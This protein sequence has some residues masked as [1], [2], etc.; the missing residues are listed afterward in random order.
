MRISVFGL[1]YVGCVTAACLARAGH[2]VV[3]M[4]TNSEKVAMINSAIPP[5]M[6]PGLEALLQEV[7]Q[8]KKLRATTSAEDAVRE[9]DACLISVGTPSSRNGEL[10][11]SALKRVGDQIGLALRGRRSHTP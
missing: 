5:L 8:G 10:D 7:V 3:G 11:V 9:T 4:D 1:G 6:E 2:E